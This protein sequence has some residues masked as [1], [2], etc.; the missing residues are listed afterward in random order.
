MRRISALFILGGLT[1]WPMLA[2]ADPFAHIQAYEREAYDRTVTEC[3]RL[4]THPSDPEAVLS[5]GVTRDEMDKHSAIE[6]CHAAL[7][8]DPDNPRLNYQ[9]ARAYGYSGLHEQGDLYRERAVK[10]GYPQSLFVVGY[11]RIEG[12]D[13]RTPDPCYGGELVRRSAQAGRFAGLV[14]FPHY[15]QT[16]AF[17]DCEDYP[18]INPEEIS[19]FLDQAAERTSGYYQTILVRSLK[20]HFSNHT[21]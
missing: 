4:A 15:V 18:V 3:D 17:S 2:S 19:V 8:S 7:E 13:G 1:I 12:W 10:A 20:A 6:A 11:I 21:D 16:G 5:E 14:G 9:L